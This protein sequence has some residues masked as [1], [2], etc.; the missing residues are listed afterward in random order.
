[1]DTKTITL[2]L[3]GQDMSGKGVLPLIHFA[4]MIQEQKT[5][6]GHLQTIWLG[7]ICSFTG[8]DREHKLN[9]N[10]HYDIIIFLIFFSVQKNNLIIARKRRMIRTSSCYMS[11]FTIFK[12]DT[13]PS[14]SFALK[15]TSMYVSYA[16]RK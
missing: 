1:M 2:L 8:S 13:A 10:N 12:R 7:M 4:H 11:P 14:Q 6:L 16:R 5:V 9:F 15:Y 3:P